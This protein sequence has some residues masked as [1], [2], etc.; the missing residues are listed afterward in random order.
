M[1]QRK[2]KKVYTAIVKDI[3]SG[4]EKENIYHSDSFVMDDM[5]GKTIKV[6]KKCEG[7]YRSMDGY[8]Y[9][10]SWIKIVREK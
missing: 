3:P 7:W 6:T 1:K 8:N 2:N 10:H 5:I 4:Q 9:H